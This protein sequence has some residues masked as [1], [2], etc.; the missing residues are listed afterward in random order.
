VRVDLG[1]TRLDERGTSLRGARAFVAAKRAGRGEAC[2]AW[3]SAFGA[4]SRRGAGS[5]RE[6]GKTSGRRFEIYAAAEE[7]RSE[8]PSL[9]RSA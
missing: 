5:S 4:G 2:S 9:R 7:K 6:G 3:R 1:S 8:V